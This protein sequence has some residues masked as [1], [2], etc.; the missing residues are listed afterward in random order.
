MSNYRADDEGTLWVKL[1]TTPGG[2]QPSIIPGHYIDM[3]MG[4]TA[5]GFHSKHPD[6]QTA[7][8]VAASLE[9]DSEHPS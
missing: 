5:W 2:I 3:R 1:H 6:R 7:Q 8:A 9:Y 4:V